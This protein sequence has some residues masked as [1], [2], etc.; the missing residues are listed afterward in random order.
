MAVTVLSIGTLLVLQGRSAAQSQSR[1]ALIIGNDGYLRPEDRLA[2][3]KNDAVAFGQMLTGAGLDFDTKIKPDLKRQEIYDAVDEMANKSNAGDLV[4]F[5]FAGHGMQRNGRNYLVPVDA[6]ISDESQIDRATLDINYIFTAMAGAQNAATIV[7]LDACRNNP[8]ERRLAVLPRSPAAIPTG[9]RSIPTVEDTAVGSR[10][11]PIGSR[12]SSTFQDTTGLAPIDPPNGILIAY[13]TS[14]GK[15]AS[16]DA[17]SGETNGLYTSALLHRIGK[18][19]ATINEILEEVTGEVLDRSTG[20]QRPWYNE[21]LRR[22]I[23]LKNI[24]TDDEFDDA[25]YERAKFIADTTRDPEKKCRM[26]KFY[27]EEFPGG[28]HIIE[29]QQYV[30]NSCPPVVAAINPFGATASVSATGSIASAA[31]KLVPEARTINGVAQTGSRLYWLPSAGAPVIALV[32]TGERLRVTGS[33]DQTFPGWLAA[34]D[35]NG[36]SGFVLADRVAR[37][38]DSVTRVAFEGAKLTTRSINE[39]RTITK[40]TNRAEIKQIEI[41]ALASDADQPKYRADRLA[42]L[43]A[44]E[45]Q[46]QLLV[47]GFP[48]EKIAAQFRPLDTAGP[49]ANLAE[50]VIRR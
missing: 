32:G 21:S 7:F 26:I 25:A 48:S 2:N 12:S 40:A 42:Y 6:E 19:G 38:N 10:S 47:L 22:H 35:R 43:R 27:L 34:T 3:A 41:T 8:F 24:V 14:P 23:V 37:S 50:I 29:V 5:F 39:L 17:G 1:R 44:M 11:S 31:A 46:A 33:A 13:A 30:R 4:V 18:A 28:R 49:N 16:D 45:V 15:T 36:R 20:K 9:S